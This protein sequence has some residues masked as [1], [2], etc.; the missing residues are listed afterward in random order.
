MYKR[1]DQY[2]TK[3]KFQYSSDGSTWHWVDNGKIFNGNNDDSSEKNIIFSTPV[4]TVGI[5]FFPINFVSEISAKM[6]L[7]IDHE[8][9]D[10]P[11][12][13]HTS[14]ATFR[15]LT[16]A[17][18]G[19]GMKNNMSGRL[20]ETDKW[21]DGTTTEDYYVKSLFT[22]SNKSHYWQINV[23]VN[24]AL[25]KVTG[26]V[27]K[28]RADTSVQYI[29]QWNFTYSTDGSTWIDVPGGTSVSYTH[30]TLP[31]TPYV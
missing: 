15:S 17:S 20:S 29:T 5:R 19:I 21:W 30:L 18:E 13:H 24:N 2:T 23:S 31:T 9:F 26:V 28:G 1:Q 4:Y 10:P 22:L 14:N 16:H 3:W 12:N 27:V 8:I 7:L 11:Y 25:K 6:A